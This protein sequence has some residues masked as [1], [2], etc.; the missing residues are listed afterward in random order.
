MEANSVSK[1]CLKD[2]FF[3][4]EALAIDT[5]V[6]FSPMPGGALTANT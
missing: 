6:I 1:E 5:E 2:Y 3:P 4:P